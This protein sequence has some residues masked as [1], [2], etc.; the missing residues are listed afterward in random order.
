M[1]LV[2]TELGNIDIV[3]WIADEVKLDVNEQTKGNGLTALHVACY[4]NRLDI[5]KYLVEDKKVNLNLREV[6]K[7]RTF[8]MPPLYRACVNGSIECV[9]I[10]LQNGADIP[11]GKNLEPWTDTWLSSFSDQL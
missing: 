3:K 6:V 8:V 10:L 7:P 1:L 4:R 11:F 2:A 9:Q 5:V